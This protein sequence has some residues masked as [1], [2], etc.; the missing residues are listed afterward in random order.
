MYNSAREAWL[1]CQADRIPWHCEC[2][3]VPGRGCGPEPLCKN[4]CLQLLLSFHHWARASALPAIS[5]AVFAPGPLIQA[6]CSLRPQ[7][8]PLPLNSYSL[9]SL[10]LALVKLHKWLQVPGN[11]ALWETAQV[12]T[13]LPSLSQTLCTSTK[14]RLCL[15]GDVHVYPIPCVFLS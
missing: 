13:V 5:D 9:F 10:Q 12:P 2:E 11:S 4:R 3:Q 6:E 14:H 1:S 15:C 7:Q 8:A